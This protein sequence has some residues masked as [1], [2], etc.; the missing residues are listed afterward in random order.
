MAGKAGVGPAHA[1]RTEFARPLRPRNTGASCFDVE[2]GDH[3]LVKPVGRAWTNG[4]VVSTRHAETF[5]VM[6]PGLDFEGVHYDQLNVYW[7]FGWARPGSRAER[8]AHREF[9]AHLRSDYYY[10]ERVDRFAFG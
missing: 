7:K 3:V 2:V 1:I 10:Q 8:L 9:V 5:S 4:V 6:F